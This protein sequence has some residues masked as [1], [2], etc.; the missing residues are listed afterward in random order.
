MGSP[1]FLELTVKLLRR[2]LTDVP[3]KK[4]GD[5]RKGL[6]LCR[7]LF[8]SADQQHLTIEREEI[9]SV[10]VDHYASRLGADS[11]RIV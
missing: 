10:H 1:V 8:E 5:L 9:S 6:H 2:L 4:I 3:V 7:F 11:T